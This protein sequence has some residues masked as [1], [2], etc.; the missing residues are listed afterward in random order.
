VGKTFDEVA[1]TRRPAYAKDADDEAF[2]RLLNERLEPLER[3]GYVDS[4]IEHPFLFVIGLPRS[5]T[6][7][8]SQL[9]AYCLD[10]GYVDNVAA[11]FWLAP[12]HGLRLAHILV[13]D[14]KPAAFESDY[15]RTHDP[16]AIHEFG[17]FWRHWLRKETFAEVVRSREL[18][19]EIDW[20]RLRVTLANV[21]RELGRAYAGK[22]MLGA[23]HTQRLT[24]VL[25]KVLWVYVERDPLDVCVSILDARRKHYDDP[26][27]WWSYVPLEYEQ[28]EHLDEWQQV[29]GQ[30][31]Y[32]QCLYEADL[33]ALGERA[34][35]TSYE[36]LC[37][38]PG[39]VLAE[40]SRRCEN[41]Y[42][43]PIALST[44]PPDSFPVRRY[45]GRDEEKA[46]FVELLEALAEGA[47]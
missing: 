42:G 4:D 39:A 28:L 29:A 21:Q 10:V 13:G 9:L 35:R 18:E 25:G 47:G 14:D 34:L 31:H 6:T 15:A 7:L 2:L 23:Y 38:D 40:V 36:E 11:R 22:N 32:L 27:T 41:L 30:V 46:R 1:S 8:L 37:R 26:R 16:R 24:E 43:E 19:S 20:D 17:Y 12:V 45:E 33:P 44:P 5:G 3:D